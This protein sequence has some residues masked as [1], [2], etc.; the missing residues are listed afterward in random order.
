MHILV[1]LVVLEK[2]RGVVICINL[3]DQPPSVLEIDE[4]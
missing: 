1:L 3:N 2:K 4:L